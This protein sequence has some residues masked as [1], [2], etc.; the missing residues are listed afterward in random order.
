MAYATLYREICTENN[1]YKIKNH[2]NK[3]I[4]DV[5]CIYPIAFTFT[6]RGEKIVTKHM[7]FFFLFQS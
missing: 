5:Q 7:G 1:I 4:K 2:Y 6:S 3:Y